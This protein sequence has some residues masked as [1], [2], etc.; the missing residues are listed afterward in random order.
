[1]SRRISRRSAE[2]SAEGIARRSLWRRPVTRP[3]IIDVLCV[4]HNVKGDRAAVQGDGY[5][6]QEATAERNSRTLITCRRSGITITAAA[7][8]DDGCCRKS[9]PQSVYRF[10]HKNVLRLN[11]RDVCEIILATLARIHIVAGSMYM[12]TSILLKQTNIILHIIYTL[13]V[14][15]YIRTNV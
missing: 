4:R 7:A 12:N 14:H 6:P 1:M 9:A 13:C 11:S 10:K 3:Y 8:C 2:G 5:A 15:T